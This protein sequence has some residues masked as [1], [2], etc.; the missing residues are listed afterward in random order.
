MTS[1][2][3]DVKKNFRKTS[4]WRP[5]PLRHYGKPVGR[6]KKTLSCLLGQMNCHVSNKNDQNIHNERFNQNLVLN[7]KLLDTKKIQMKLS[8]DL[9]AY[10]YTSSYMC[11]VICMHI[12]L[13]TCM[14]LLSV[15]ILRSLKLY[16]MN[17]GYRSANVRQASSK[18][19]K[20]Y[21]LRFRSFWFIRKLKESQFVNIEGV[22]IRISFAALNC[23]LSKLGFTLS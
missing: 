15:N 2:L 6:P 12:F 3:T 7:S 21:P 23:Y 8:D 18:E 1:V 11:N 9:Y 10:A 19:L 16:F 4:H 22:S 5:R 20:R 14:H 17:F 13:Y